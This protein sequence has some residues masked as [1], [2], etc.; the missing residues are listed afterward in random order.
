MLARPLLDHA[1]ARHEPAILGPLGFLGLATLAGLAAG[2]GLLHQDGLGEIPRRRPHLQ[3]H[4]DDGEL[5][6]VELLERSPL[7]LGELLAPVENE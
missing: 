4:G 3:A 1:H 2:V 6:Q 5:G 7:F